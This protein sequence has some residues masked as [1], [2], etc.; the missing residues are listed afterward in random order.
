MTKCHIYYLCYDNGIPFYV[1]KTKNPSERFYYHRRKY[2]LEVKLKVIDV[3]PLKEWKFWEQYWISQ[4]RTWEYL[5]ENKNNGGNGPTSLT[6]E[7]ILKIKNS[8]LSVNPKLSKQRKGYSYPQTRN[9]KISNSMKGHPPFHQKSILQ[10][11]KT[12]KF[13][14]E[15][16]SI[17]DARTTLKISTNNIHTALND[18]SKSAGGFRWKFNAI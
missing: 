16:S 7:Q 3:V 4:F 18:F 10:Y 14:K 17:K 2:G 15:W 13:I 9:Q 11:S 8:R 12:G 1:G 5:L 6:P